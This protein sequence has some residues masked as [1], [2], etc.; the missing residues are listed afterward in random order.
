MDAELLPFLA[1]FTAAAE[2]GSFT[3]V[4]RHFGLS[5]AAVSQRIQ[6]LEIL[7]NTPLFRRTGGRVELTAAGRR[8][9][10]YARRIL[11]L[12]AEAWRDVTGDQD[13][14]TGELVLAASSVPG[15]HLLPHVLAGFGERYPL[16]TVRVT[17]SD[18]ESALRLVEQG[19]AH[20]ALVGGPGGGPNLEFRRFASDELVVVIP[21]R[22]PWWRKRRVTP[23]ELRTQPIIQRE[24]GSGSRRCFENSLERTGTDPSSLRVAL[25]LDSTEAIKGAVIEG[26]GIAVMSRLAVSDDLKTGRLKP[27]RVDGL[28]L[29]RD[30][31]VVW[32][33]RRVLSVPAS[34]FLALVAPAI[35]PS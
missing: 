26:M 23:A 10:G 30:I 18:T 6:Q 28:A 3:A 32:D 1:T 11:D 25:E 15:H 19:R 21:K 5:Q 7:L 8:L 17:V 35:E 27:L 29:G 24:R 13:E 12:T 16:V 33:R 14:V 31:S 4:A 22:H 20:L 2:R 34:H 9:H